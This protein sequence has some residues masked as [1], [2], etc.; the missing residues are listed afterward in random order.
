MWLALGTV[1]SVGKHD[2]RFLIA[3]KFRARGL[4][5]RIHYVTVHLRWWQKEARS[6]H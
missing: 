6:A 4:G 1:P 3:E 5:K 2:D